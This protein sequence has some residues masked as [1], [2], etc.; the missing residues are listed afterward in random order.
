M[1]EA[2]SGSTEAKRNTTLNP[3]HPHQGIAPEEKQQDYSKIYL[4]PDSASIVS[5]MS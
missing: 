2:I 5:S 4:Q 1:K 3:G